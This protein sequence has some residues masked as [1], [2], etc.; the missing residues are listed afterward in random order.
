MYHVTAILLSAGDIA[1][2][3]ANITYKAHITKWFYLMSILSWGLE[4]R[5]QLLICTA[6]L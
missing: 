3:K 1:I 5:F 4:Y 2:N 6:S